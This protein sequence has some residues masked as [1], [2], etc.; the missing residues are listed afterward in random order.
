MAEREPI[1][2]D[3][4]FI[5]RVMATSEFLYLRL[6]TSPSLT[7][8]EMDDTVQNFRHELKDDKQ[9]VFLKGV[10]YMSLLN[11]SL[12]LFMSSF[13]HEMGILARCMDEALEDV[14][15]FLRRTG[16]NGELSKRQTEALAEFYQEEFENISVGM[17]RNNE[18][19]RV[20]RKSVR[21][22]IAAL[23]ENEVNP[24]DMAQIHGTIYDTFSGYVHGAYPHIMELYG[25]WPPRY[26]TQGMRGSPRQVEGA[27][28]LVLYVHRGI[29]IGHCVAMK[30]ERWDIADQILTLRS[31]LEEP[32]PHLAQ[33]PHASLAALK[34]KR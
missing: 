13:F 33:D 27:R 8:P 26:H 28:Q 20:P 11:A 25:G 24:H 32:Y 23:P 21:A 18:R 9:F 4:T 12:T 3:L 7:A 6:E 17:L 31:A 30:L 19:R 1:E 22:A 15:F 10:R 34:R 29:M 5:R 16:E 2:F 14:M